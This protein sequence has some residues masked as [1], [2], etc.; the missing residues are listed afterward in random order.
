LLL[1]VRDRLPRLREIILI[2]GEAAGISRWAQVLAQGRSVAAL[3]GRLLKG[4]WRQAAP[5]DLAALIY[6]AGTAGQPEAIMLTH[7]NLRYHQAAVLAAV[8][9]AEHSGGDG[10]TRL[11]SYMP[12]AHV[13]GRTIDHWGR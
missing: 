4:S 1:S 9:L 10:I 13:T 6:T 8:Q 3:G 5:G 12:M 2:G 7:R 11:V